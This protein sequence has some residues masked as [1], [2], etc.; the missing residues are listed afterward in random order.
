MSSYSKSKS[1]NLALI[2]TVV[3]FCLFLVSSLAAWYLHYRLA[4]LV[5]T[6]LTLLALVLLCICLWLKHKAHQNDQNKA[7]IRKLTKYLTWAFNKVPR[8]HKYKTPCFLALSHETAASASLLENMGF[9][10]LQPESSI[11]C[12]IQA[13]HSQNCMLL[14]TTPQPHDLKDREGEWFAALRH[15]KQRRP[16]Q[17]LSGILVVIPAEI[18]ST[19]TEQN[20]AY[21]D[22]ISALCNSVSRRLKQKL[23]V[24]LL[25]SGTDQLRCFDDL[26]QTL[27]RDELASPL[28]Y[29]KP[30]EN[31]ESTEDWFNASWQ[32]LLQ[33][34]YQR[35]TEA[36][37]QIYDPA[38]AKTSISALFQISLLGDRVKSVLSRFSAA[39]YSN[40]L[41]IAGYFVCMN[42]S[43]S[44][45][46]DLTALY[47][48]YHFATGRHPD[49]CALKTQHS[50]F[51]RDLIHRIFIPISTRTGLNRRSEFTYQFFRYSWY[52]LG[53]AGLGL[54]AWW[55]LA[56]Y[57][58]EDRL[59]M[60]T[61]AVISRYTMESNNKTTSLYVT[62][63]NLNAIR[64]LLDEYNQVPTLLAASHMSHRKVKSQLTDYYHQQLKL[65]LAPYLI[66]VY[67]GSLSSQIKQEHAHGIFESL[68][69]YQMLFDAS[70]LKLS[71]LYKSTLVLLTEHF[72]LDKVSK[73]KLEALLQDYLSLPDYPAYEPDMKL[74]ADARAR[75]QGLT[76]AHLVY[77]RIKVM[78]EYHEYVPL[79][80]MM[81]TH[82][83]KVFAIDNAAAS[84]CQKG[85]FA[86]FTA[87][88]WKADLS[89]DS[90]L[91]ISSLQD[92]RKLQGIHKPISSK[93]AVTISDAVR[94]RFTQEY[95]SRWHG[96]L[97]CIY[98]DPV[99]SLDDL[100]VTISYLAQWGKSPMNDILETVKANT[101]FPAEVMHADNNPGGGNEEASG[102]NI[103]LLATKTATGSIYNEDE[104]LT[105]AFADYHR[106]LDEKQGV[107]F[108]QNFQQ[109]L[110]EIYHNLHQLKTSDNQ[111]E[112]AFLQVKQ[113]ASGSHPIKSLSFLALSQPDAVRRWM[114]QVI[115]E[116][117]RLYTRRAEQFVQ[118]RWQEEVITP[119]QQY[120]ASRFPVSATSN[121]HVDPDDFEDFFGPKG[122]LQRF[123]TTYVSPF[124][125][126]HAPIRII[127]Q[128]NM[129]F[130]TA[131]LDL[132]RRVEGI[133]KTC[134]DPTGK[135][136]IDM[137]VRVHSLSPE[138]THFTISDGAND[139]TYNHGPALWQKVSW[140]VDDDNMVLT[141]AFYAADKRLSQNSYSG[142]W[143]W[144]QI[145][146]QSTFIAENTENFVQL[147]HE[148]AGQVVQLHLKGPSRSQSIEHILNALKG[149]SMP[150]SVLR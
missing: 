133:R 9:E 29:I 120:L 95:I 1:I 89:P 108:S 128:Q 6:G 26:C 59:N 50:A 15:I 71:E 4:A 116:W 33:K 11:H 100:E 57:T 16:R 79:E 3:L 2:A 144:L 111:S 40:D 97:S 12:D 101:W 114:E 60:A 5:A 39:F 145:I 106:L 25:I 81:G 103:D 140:P 36:L 124:V 61:T 115:S 129:R 86:L 7:S 52:C 54:T 28:G 118:S 69:L 58:T 72:G 83:D 17:P 44:Q 143:A 32:A 87:R 90:D 76:D 21:L 45:L 35:Q 113:L 134:F 66:E 74:I 47:C 93:T 55:L 67:S 148:Q 77:R 53:L 13:W 112:L 146:S 10:Y 18:L 98:I 131:F 27:H 80:K 70:E 137:F 8:R 42:S 135:L 84:N 24:V 62:L 136:N 88:G 125:S 22:S 147:R 20:E 105:E 14:H 91:I 19:D 41:D 117:A 85:H 49:T 56:N 38:S 48:Q 119:W 150:D 94:Q 63:S 109:L 31:K 107:A 126:N 149:M 37:G 34:L 92:I 142:P 99:T 96:T 110:E 43:S 65:R 23:P 127:A 73:E 130:S 122:R 132:F 51:S 121:K 102:E 78:P 46:L 138:A 123:H 75:L 64:E 82:F 68:R 139:I 141:S 104:I 30:L